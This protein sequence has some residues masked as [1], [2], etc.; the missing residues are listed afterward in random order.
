MLDSRETFRCAWDV[1]TSV[2]CNV[3]AVMQWH[4]TQ[5]HQGSQYHSHTTQYKQHLLEHKRFEV[6]V[7]WQ[8]YH[9]DHPCLHAVEQCGV[10]HRVFT[11][12]VFHPCS[13]RRCE[14]STIRSIAHP[15]VYPLEFAWLCLQN[16]DVTLRD[17]QYVPVTLGGDLA[18]AQ[19][20]TCWQQG[21]TPSLV[22]L[23][24]DR[25]MLHSLVLVD[26]HNL[27]LCP[28]TGPRG[29]ML[30]PSMRKRTS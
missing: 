20:Q 28:I 24:S 17:D 5:G 1:A 9:A 4:V 8:M 12:V 15:D 16:H 26:V 3:C 25:N 6:H 11:E 10:R 19:A 23:T 7:G 14:L 27:A 29:I 21:L 30:N 13:K 2:L 22:T 18:R